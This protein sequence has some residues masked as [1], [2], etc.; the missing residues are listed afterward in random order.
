MMGIPLPGQSNIQLRFTR[1][2]MLAG[3]ACI[4][5]PL[6]GAAQKVIISEDLRD[7]NQIPEYGVNR[8]HFRHFY[9]GFHGI[10]GAPENS[11]ASILYGKSWRFEFGTRR[12]RR[13]NQTFSAGYDLGFKREGYW[14]QQSEGK[15][16]PTTMVYEQEKLVVLGTGLTIFQRINIGSRGNHMGRFMDV[17][18][19]GD[20]HFHT[21]HVSF[22]KEGKERIRTRRSGLSYPETFVYGGIVRI[23]YGRVALKSTYRVSD[24]FGDAS[25]FP[26]LPRFTAGIEFGMH[27]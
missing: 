16:V 13:F 10:V 11:G 17:G 27:P 20:W 4:L 9:T 2:I 5:F 7:N 22:E 1:L 8:K 14:M 3:L 15:L 25:G 18:V 6:I 12:I 24:L 21:R 26:E 23:G 19:F